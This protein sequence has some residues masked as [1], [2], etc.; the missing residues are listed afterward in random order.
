MVGGLLKWIVSSDT[1]TYTTR[2]ALVA[3]MAACLKCIG[4]SIGKIRTWDGSEDLPSNLDRNAFVVVLGGSSPTDR[5][6]LDAE[7]FPSD[8]RTFHYQFNSVGAMILNALGNQSTIFPEVLQGHFEYVHRCIEAAGRFEYEESSDVTAL[9]EARFR[10][11]PLSTQS[12]PLERRFAA[13]YLPLSAE[14]IAPCYRA[15]ATEDNL[16]RLRD[17]DALHGGFQK[18]PE[19]VCLFRAIT[20]AI[21]ISIVSRLAPD[22]FKE[23]QHAISLT[24]THSGWLDEMCKPLDQAFVS[25][26]KYNQIVSVLAIIHSARDPEKAFETNKSIVAWRSGIYSVVP[27]LLL[28]MNAS[29][30]AVTPQCT[31]VYWANVKVREDG[32]IYSAPTGAILEDDALIDEVQEG[33]ASALQSLSRP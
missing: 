10:Q 7:D 15:I 26:L 3:R 8:D 28:S 14:L 12:T 18:V 24:L 16:R 30:S 9:V 1:S 21:V 5:L 29:P 27:S 6:M 13:M 33:N 20:A 4:Y 32:S 25:G 31:D 23:T 22:G 11:A 17:H 19:D 2:S